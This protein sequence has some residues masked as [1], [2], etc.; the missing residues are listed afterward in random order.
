MLFV[1]EVRWHW[2][3]YWFR[4]LGHVRVG[5]FESGAGQKCSGSPLFLYVIAERAQ[6]RSIRFGGRA[7]GAGQCIS[8]IVDGGA[9]YG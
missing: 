6:N 2:I 7:N 8:R 4:V 5:G 3:A 1:V 9:I